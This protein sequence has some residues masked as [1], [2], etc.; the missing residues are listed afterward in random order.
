MKNT[1]FTILERNL[2]TGEVNSIDSQIRLNNKTQSF[3]FD[4]SFEAFVRMGKTVMM[5]SWTE[6]D[7]E[8]KSIKLWRNI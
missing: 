8:C 7:E 4:C 6:G 5:N 3:S 2:E 1:T